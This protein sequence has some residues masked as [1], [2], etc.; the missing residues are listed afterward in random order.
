M[1]KIPNVQY[2]PM[3]EN[4]KWY[5]CPHCHADFNYMD[6]IDG[7]AA[8]PINTHECIYQ[9]IECKKEFRMLK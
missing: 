5:H 4:E 3:S 2:G 9:C 1:N 7:T 6:V 8:I